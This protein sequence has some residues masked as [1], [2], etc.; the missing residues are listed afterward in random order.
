MDIF[1]HFRFCDGL[2]DANNVTGTH[3]ENELDDKIAFG[4]ITA[5]SARCYTLIVVK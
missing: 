3:S 1:W 5:L 4:I 2:P